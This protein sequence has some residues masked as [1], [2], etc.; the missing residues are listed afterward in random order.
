M[1]AEN[2]N[3]DLADL[4]ARHDQLAAKP[5]QVWEILHDGADRARVIAD[6]TM[7]E[8]RAAIGFAE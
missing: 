1:L 7:Q 5:A 4:R 3:K 8:V 6:A 2:I